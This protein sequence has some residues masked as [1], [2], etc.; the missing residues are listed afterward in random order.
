MSTVASNGAR[1]TIT[2]PT[3]LQREVTLRG[4]GRGFHLITDDVVDALPELS[5]IDCGIA[6]VF[7]KHTSAALTI[8]EN[9]AAEVL[10]DFRSWFDLA[11]PEH[12][13]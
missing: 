8:N 3:W 7:I 9:I 1:R 10:A 5:L 11:V 13:P 12:A 2:A 6:H 4:R